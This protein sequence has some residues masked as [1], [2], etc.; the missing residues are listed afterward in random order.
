L[1][2]FPHIFFYDKTEL[3]ALISKGGFDVVQAWEEPFVYAGYQVA[4]SVEGGHARFCFRTDQ[5][6]VKRYPPP[7]SC[8]EKRV[9]QRT[10]GWIAGGKLV[11]QAMLERNYPSDTG[12]ILDAAVDLEAFRPATTEERNQVRSELALS[13]PVIGF[14][15]R[16]TKAKGLEVLTQALD[17][18][19]DKDWAL[20]IL[21]SGP[22]KHEVQRWSLERGLAKRVRILLANHEEVPRYL[23]AMSMLVVPSQTTKNWREQFGRV[24]IE[25][26]ASG[27]P[28]I[29]SD[30]G[31]IPRVI[32]EAGKIVGEADLQGW[33]NA[34]VSLLDED[35]LRARLS[36]LGLRR[37]QDFS[38]VR[39]GQQYREYYSWLAK[40]PLN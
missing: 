11:Y 20:L 1:T 35:V 17:Q 8:F 10:Q 33:A 18:I 30:S 3:N 5:N 4:T 36:S 34:I 32:G 27:I 39:L 25:A 13:G 16:L 31:E 26:F 6:Y 24:I 21:G 29:G 12:W 15:G 7:F 19:I 28:V 40:Q 22:Y 2:R 38:V 23:R 9:L 14:V 37:A